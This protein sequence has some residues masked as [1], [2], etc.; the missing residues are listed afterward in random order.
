[1]TALFCRKLSNNLNSHQKEALDFIFRRESDYVPES[2]SLFK[3]CIDPRNRTLYVITVLPISSSVAE[4]SF[5][6]EHVIMGYK[7]P[8]KPTEGFGGIIA[9]EM[10]LGKTLLLLSAIALSLTRAMQFAE[11][12]PI[13]GQNR[14]RSRATLVICP[15]VC[16]I[17]PL[18]HKR[19]ELIRHIFSAYGQLGERN[20]KVCSLH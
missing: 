13:S 8:E 20:L 5:S 14:V 18:T 3:T 4:W 7:T 16:K 15:S 6:F 19:K 12:V 2:L 17:I 1:V 9:D 11:L 10:G